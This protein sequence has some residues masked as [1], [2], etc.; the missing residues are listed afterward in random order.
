MKI[1]KLNSFCYKKLIIFAKST[2][3][4]R[5]ITRLKQN[6]RGGNFMSCCGSSYFRM[7]KYQS[8]KKKFGSVLFYK[9]NS[10]V[11]QFSF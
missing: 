11:N 7:W 9:K 3:I 8:L 2:T 5:E 1:Q 6:F 10:R 4:E